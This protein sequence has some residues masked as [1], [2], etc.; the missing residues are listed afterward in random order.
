MTCD[1]INYK[2]NNEPLTIQIRYHRKIE[3]FRALGRLFGVLCLLPQD[4]TISH[5]LNFVETAQFQTLGSMTDCSRC[6]VLTLPAVYKLLRYSA[7]MGLNTFQL[8][9]EDTF[10]VKFFFSSHQIG[11]FLHPDPF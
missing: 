10:Q 6:A 7:L 11:N 4:G 8:Y 9:T 3:A 1:S 5:L 2:T